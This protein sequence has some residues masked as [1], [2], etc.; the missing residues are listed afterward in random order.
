M[1]FACIVQGGGFITQVQMKKLHGNI[2]PEA[3]RTQLEGSLDPVLGLTS[4]SPRSKK[5]QP[6]IAE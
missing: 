6:K 1:R 3:F 2:G 4:G 5:S